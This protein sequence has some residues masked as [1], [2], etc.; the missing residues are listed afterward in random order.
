MKPLIH[1]AHAN[2]FP[3]A[4][5][6]ALF[7]ALSSDYEVCQLPLAGHDPNY[8]VTDNWPHLKQQLI[9]SIEAQCDRPVIG[10]GHSLGGGLTMMAARERPDLF[11]AI[12]LLDVPLFN[13]LES[14]LVRAVKQLGLV[15][16]VTPAGRSKRRRTQWPDAETALNYFRTRGLFS[17]FDERCLR[18]YVDS[19]LRPAANGGVELAY[20]LEVELAIFRSMPHTLA[21]RAGQLSMPAGILVGRDTDTVRKSQY[22]RMKRRLGFYGERIEGTHMFPLEYPE[23]TAAAINRQLLHM[24]LDQQQVG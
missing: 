11:A 5:Y 8:P 21:V 12:L 19:A 7:A 3:S 13:C 4:S 14:L 17:R 6:N 9:D 10:L 2:G 15:D 16:A 1:F 24:Q 22:L 23:Q 20:E 18:D